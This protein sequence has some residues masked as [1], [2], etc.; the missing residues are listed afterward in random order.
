MK[1]ALSVPGHSF[2]GTGNGAAGRYGFGQAV[3]GLDRESVEE[4]GRPFD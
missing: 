3:D 4:S 2:G 1:G